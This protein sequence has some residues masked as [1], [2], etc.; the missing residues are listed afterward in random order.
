MSSTPLTS[1]WQT[2][3][4]TPPFD[5]IKNEHYE[6]AFH[7]ALKIAREEIQAIAD[8]QEDPT[9]DN[10]LAALDRS[11]ELLDSISNIFFNL[12][13]CNTSKELQDIAQK[14]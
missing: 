7:H 13:V 2:P 11:G 8:N 1:P 3:Y 12:L 10:T 6:P 14:I 5:E 9:F 4:Q